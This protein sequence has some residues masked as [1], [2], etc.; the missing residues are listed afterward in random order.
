M[1]NNRITA[2][3]VAAACVATAFGGCSR[4]GTERPANAEP[5]L[6]LSAS[7]PTAI[8][9][10]APAGSA[11]STD[12]GAPPVAV[13]SSTPAPPAPLTME[14]LAITD[15]KDPAYFYRPTRADTAPQPLVVYLHGACA[16][17]DW[18]CPFFTGA[19][20]AAWLLCPPAAAPCQ[21]GGVMWAG[22]TESLA[23]AV[24]RGVVALDPK[25]RGVDLERRA[26]I[27]FSLGGPA[28]LRIALHEP[29][30]WQRLMVVN[31]NV[32]PSPAQLRKAGI[33]RVALVAGQ[34]DPVAP[35]LRRGAKWL[36]N[37]HV[38]VR[39]FV[40]AEMGHYYDSRSTERFNA[41]LAWLMADWQPR[42][43]PPNPKPRAK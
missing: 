36:S 15:V 27:G 37:K 2:G 3:I 25:A 30:R 34:H 13:A 11:R 9:R 38:D 8:E 14:K 29:G 7:P 16:Y 39:Y 20:P 18:E 1:A 28:A 6:P 4:S 10:P 35:K 22:S 33:D 40:I 42:A 31:A 19:S 12:A 41:P 23:S 21:G 26:I 43:A 24:E 32:I 5:A 17:P